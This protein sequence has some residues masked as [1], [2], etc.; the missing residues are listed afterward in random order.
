MNLSVN[1]LVLQI[2]WHSSLWVEIQKG[3]TPVNKCILYIYM[4]QILLPLLREPSYILYILENTKF[5]QNH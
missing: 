1:I 5:K 3:L 4:Y 2:S